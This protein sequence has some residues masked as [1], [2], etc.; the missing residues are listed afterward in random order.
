MPPLFVIGADGEPQIANSRIHQNI[1]IV[2]RLF[3]A[4]ELRL[5]SGERQQTVRIL[6]TDGVR[7]GPRE[8]M[9]S[10]SGAS[11]ETNARSLSGGQP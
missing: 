1:L 10:S 6:R 8:G 5:G 3:G 11:Q 7:N 4:A 2:D 9:G